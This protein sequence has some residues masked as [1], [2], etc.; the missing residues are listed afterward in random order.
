MALN[1]TK[2]GPLRIEHAR[3]INFISDFMAAHRKAA[4]DDA[5]KA[6]GEIKAMD[7]PKTYASW[8]KAR[9]AG[10]RSSIGT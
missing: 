3:Y 6:W 8:A 4:H 1:K 5:V 10:R 2:R 7:A 9:K